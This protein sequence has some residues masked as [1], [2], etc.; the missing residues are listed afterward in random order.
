[1]SDL[2]NI[3]RWRSASDEEIDLMKR[4]YQDGVSFQMSAFILAASIFIVPCAFLLIVNAIFLKITFIY[5][6]VLLIVVCTVTMIVPLYHLDNRY[7]SLLSKGSFK[8][9]HGRIVNKNP[10]HYAFD[11]KEYSVLFEDDSGNRKSVPVVTEDYLKATEGACLIVKWEN[12]FQDGKFGIVMC[13][14]NDNGWRRASVSEARIVENHV[15]NI[16]RKKRNDM[17]VSLVFMLVC[18]GVSL[19]AVFFKEYSG[20]SVCIIGAI[21]AVCCLVNLLKLQNLPKQIAAG[22]YEVMTGRIIDKIVVKSRRNSAYNI[23][24]ENEYGYTLKLNLNRKEYE[25]V[26]QEVCLVYKTKSV[27]FIKKDDINCLNY[28]PLYNDEVN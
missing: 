25:T 17:I 24:F 10:E 26:S 18:I 3:Y 8:V 6:S 20:M 11:I 23:I 2:I 1:M 21:A 5:V 14:N 27:G 4:W 19:I 13:D 28:D 12:H 7:S 16:Y 15:P 22:N 9:Q